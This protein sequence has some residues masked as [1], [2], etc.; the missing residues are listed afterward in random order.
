MRLRLRAGPR[1][2]R[3]PLAT[4]LAEPWH[5]PFFILHVDWAAARSRQQYG[6]F[7]APELSYCGMQLFCWLYGFC[8]NDTV[9]APTA[10]APANPSAAASFITVVVMAS[11]PFPARCGL[12]R[13]R[14]AVPHACE[15]WMP[16]T[17]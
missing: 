8:A 13:R 6:A 2:Q 14:P 3:W 15:I 16:R 1:P 5:A 12:A 4:K 10:S 11:S 9:A 17:L 7:C